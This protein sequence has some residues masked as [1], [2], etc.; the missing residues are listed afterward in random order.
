MPA[1]DVDDVVRVLALQLLDRADALAAELV[2]QIL[3][4]DPT[5]GGRVP[6]D[7]LRTSVRDNICEVIRAVAGAADDRRLDPPRATG[8]RR[9]EQG[10]PLESLLHSYRIGGRLIWQHLVHLARGGPEDHLDALL[11][12]A[13]LVWDAIDEFSTVVGE[14]YR[15][16][17]S[18]LARIDL[19]RQAATVEALLAGDRRSSVVQRATELLGPFHALV[20]VVVERGDEAV[21]PTPAAALRAIGVRSL[22]QERPPG[23]VGVVA[24]P[25]G[26]LTGLAAALRDVVTGRAGVSPVVHELRSLPQAYEQAEL[27]L[28]VAGSAPDVAILSERLRAGVAAA[29][30]SLGALLVEQ[31]LGPLDEVGEP[32]SSD[33]LAALEAYLATG[34]AAATAR[35]LHCHRNTVL[36]RLRRV[37]ELTGLDVAVPGD[38]ATLVLALDVRLA[39]QVHTSQG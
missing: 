17:E 19:Q 38:L 20:I 9:A 31:A 27:A 34:S 29:A 7:D 12:G 5:Y 1:A 39:G 28:R 14:A 18:R 22:W 2:D 8:R 3:A 10:L 11:D 16:T 15:A 35:R 21:S 30:G 25:S 13:T 32:E 4:D 24:L 26:M 33:L 37:R 36:N 6:A 23:Q